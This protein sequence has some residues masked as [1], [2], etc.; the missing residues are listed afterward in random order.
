MRR[1][2]LRILA[3]LGVRSAYDVFLK[4]LS[5]PD[6]RLVELA[7][8]GL[9]FVEH[10]D[11]FAALCRQANAAAPRVRAAAMRGLGYC[12][13]EKGAPEVLLASLADPD[14]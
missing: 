10:P 7:T 3:A 5:D 2:A 4:G 1:A 6:E 11:A 8:Y 12:A 13:G 14:P 9:A